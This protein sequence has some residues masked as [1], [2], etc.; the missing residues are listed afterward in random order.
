MTGLVAVKEKSDGADDGLV[1]VELLAPLNENVDGGAAGVDE[2]ND[3][4]GGFDGV[5]SLTKKFKLGRGVSTVGKPNVGLS[6]A[7]L[8]KLDEAGV[9][10]GVSRTL[11]S[12]NVGD[13]L[14]SSRSLRCFS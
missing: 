8:A 12:F 4:V 5:E 1:A 9:A 10:F 11:F 6:S 2:P 14:F 13:F 7:L 3:S